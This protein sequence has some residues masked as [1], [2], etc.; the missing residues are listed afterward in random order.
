[1]N[2]RRARDEAL[3]DL[4]IIVPLPNNVLYKKFLYCSIQII[5]I[6]ATT[7]RRVGL[8]HNIHLT[9]YTLSFPVNRQINDKKGLKGQQLRMTNHANYTWMQ[10]T[11]NYARPTN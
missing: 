11:I 6:K 5:N 1:M 2:V 9:I 10:E 7:N 3:N 8:K 4:L